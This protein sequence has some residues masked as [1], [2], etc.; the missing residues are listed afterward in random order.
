MAKKKSGGVSNRPASTGG[1]SN[2]GLVV[3]LVIAIL[4][5]VTLGV[6]TY[7]GYSGQADLLTQA[8]KAN[9]DKAAADKKYDEEKL[10]RLVLAIATGTSEDFADLTRLKGQRKIDEFTKNLPGI[11]WS[12]ADPRPRETYKDL[13]AKMAAERKSALDAKK[14][15]EDGLQT[16]QK[17]YQDQRSALEKQLADAKAALGQAN[18]AV[19]ATRKEEHDKYAKDIADIDNVSEKLKVEKQS[20]E[21]DVAR[22][23]REKSTLERRINDLNEQL[24]FAK[25]QVV[26]AS[27]FEADAAKGKI[28]R[29]DREAGLAYINLGSADF[30]RPL[31]TFSV[32]SPSIYSETAAKREAKGTVEVV[33]VLEPHLSTVRITSTVNALRDPILAGDLL[34]NPAWNSNQRVH[35]ALVGI[36]D[37][38]NDGHDDTAE[39]VRNL[40]RMGIV[41]D[42]WFDL[43]EQV[44]RGPGITERTSFLLVGEKPHI[45]ESIARAGNLADNPIAQAVAQVNQKIGEIEARAKEKG[46][47]KANYR[48]YLTLIGYQMPKPTRA[49]DAAATTYVRPVHEESKPAEN[50]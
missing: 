48:R 17:E 31:L 37:L 32:F 41:V 16:A 47:E 26:S 1:E 4:L 50:K 14:V 29:V 2:T 35:V 18:A 9:A 49:F 46:V 45:S 8:K 34:F 21:D 20:R 10:N 33:Q 23:T 39:V 36:F 28:T 38:D 11:Q 42:A 30:V 27:S 24:R 22:M 7:L 15:A 43:R 44:L 12:D 3:S 25:S 13:F 5:A 6:F 40:E 19:A